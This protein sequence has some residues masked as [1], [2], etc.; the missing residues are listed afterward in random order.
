[1]NL[2]KGAVFTYDVVTF[3]FYF[4]TQR[5]WQKQRKSRRQRAVQV[6]PSDVH[7]PWIR[8]GRP[9]PCL[10]DHVKT[11]DEFMRAAIA[12]HRGKRCLGVRPVLMEE[13]VSDAADGHGAAGGGK[14]VKKTMADH[15]EWIV[16]K[17]GRWP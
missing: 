6:N 8:V 5:P 12:Q 16:S 2:V 17:C 11:V 14:S 3:P 4:A 1:M 7:S 13:L 9:K 15:F 10:A